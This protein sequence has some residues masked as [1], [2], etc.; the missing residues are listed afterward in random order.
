VGVF[1][2]AALDAVGQWRSRPP[3]LKDGTPPRVRAEVTVSFT[4]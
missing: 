1:A 3:V 2:R 4:R